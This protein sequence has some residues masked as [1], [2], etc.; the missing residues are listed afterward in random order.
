VNGPR[1]PIPA[2]VSLL[3]EENAVATNFTGEAD[4]AGRTALITGAG[5][6]VG[7]AVA[8]GLA[9]DGTGEIWDV[10]TAPAQS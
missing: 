3:T 9:G 6:G 10:S 4:F 5:R 2:S 1:L 8:L 7:R